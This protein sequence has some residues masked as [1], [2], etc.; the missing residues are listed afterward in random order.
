M[1]TIWKH[2]QG[3]LIETETITQDCWVHVTAPDQEEVRMLSE[4]FPVDIDTL[5]DI[6]D[7]D[8]QSRIERE[9]EWLL[10]I[11][12]VP[13]F[14]ANEEVPYYTVPLG[15]ILYDD[16]LITISVCENPILKDFIQGKIRN[17]S[18]ANKYSFVLHIFMRSAFYFLRYLKDINRKT[19]IVEKDLQQSV[20]NNE[21]IQLLTFEKCLV[22]FTTSLK[23][24]ELL[25]EKM[26]KPQLMRFKETE[27]DFLED[28][29]TENEQAIEMANIYS[30]I[31]SGMMDAFAS[32]I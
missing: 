27:M 1:M 29:L 5:N 17:L 11:I 28:C 22:Y 2:D 31:L 9:D 15:V 19:S 23:S 10:L 24:N 14:N 7:V 18:L 8:E 13:V 26:R 25:M 16:I 3:K 32:V 6:L 30:N 12:R 21:L 20:K 4:M